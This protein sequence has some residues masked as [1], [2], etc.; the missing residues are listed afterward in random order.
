[1][2]Q[3]DLGIETQVPTDSS[4][5]YGGDYW[6]DLPRV[7]EYMNLRTT[8]DP[9]TFWMDDFHRRFCQDGPFEEALFVACG[10]GW[11]ERSFLDR[12]IAR[13]AVAFD[14]SQDLLD[15]AQRDRGDRPITYFQADVN[16]VDLP[17]DRFDLIVNVGAL[18]HVQFINR[19]SRVLCS[20]LRPGGVLVAFDYIGPARNQYPPQQW[21][22]IRRANAQLPPSLRKDRLRRP[23]LP[24]MLH[25][26]PTEAIHSDLVLEA[27]ARYFTIVERHDAGGGIAYEVITHNPKF[28]GPVA[29]AEMLPH[30]ERLLEMDAELT[31]AGTVPSLF[32][33]YIARPEKARLEDGALA[34]HQAAEDAREAWA[35][36]HGGVYS[37]AEHWRLQAAR[38]FW[39]PA[40]WAAR[41]RLGRRLRRYLRR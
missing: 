15:A 25:D 29:E 18:H 20:T 12:G 34:E 2:T 23:H 10:N 7:L 24:T 28:F 32:S 40:R 31:A 17:P 3:P 5:Y 11:V 21:E 27:L 1:M 38:A 41:T 9:A 8:G 22:L 39:T 16:L 13:S 14:Y 36:R 6:N 4:V 33:Y 37:P 19:F 35:A 26:D 30:I